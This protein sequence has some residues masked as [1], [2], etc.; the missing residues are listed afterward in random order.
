MCY[1]DPTSGHVFDFSSVIARGCDQLL[2]PV[3]LLIVLRFLRDQCSS[4]GADLRPHVSFELLVEPIEQF[5]TRKT[6]TLVQVHRLL[7]PFG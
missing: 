2:V 5:C 7:E 6:V 4:D 1:G 3:V